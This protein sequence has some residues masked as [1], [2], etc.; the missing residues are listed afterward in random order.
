MKRLAISTAAAALA[1]GLFAVPASASAA[2]ALTQRQAESDV[3]QAAYQEYGFN[4]STTG[5]SC[6]PKGHSVE[7]ASRF[8]GRYHSWV[9]G[10]AGGVPDRSLECSGAMSIKGTTSRVYTFRY[11]VLIGARC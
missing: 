1:L 11:I 10:W 8:P 4:R 9:C 2:W 5:A 3:R 7:E 6:R